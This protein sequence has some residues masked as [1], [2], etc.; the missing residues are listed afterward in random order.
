[1]SLLATKTRR[2]LVGIRRWFRPLRHIEVEDL[3][4]QLSGDHVYLVGEDGIWWSAAMVCPCGCQSI[5]QLSLIADDR[6][7]WRAHIESDGAVTLHPSVWRTKGC[8]SHF[9]VRSGRIK[10]ARGWHQNG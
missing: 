8:N 2:L 1:M 9:F 7:R 6:P 5:I 4:E 3:P 10:W